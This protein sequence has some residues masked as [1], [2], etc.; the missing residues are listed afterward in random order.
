MLCIGVKEHV[1]NKLVTAPSLGNPIPNMQ[2]VK[3]IRHDTIAGECKVIY[4]T[5]SG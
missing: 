3:E 2:Q 5:Q 4:K 1:V